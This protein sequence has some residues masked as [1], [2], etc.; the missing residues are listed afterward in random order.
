MPLARSVFGR[1]I[2]VTDMDFL[3][4]VR[5][6]SFLSEIVYIVLNV[7]LA[8][9]L[10]FLVRITGSPFP[11]FAFVI[12]SMWRV[13]AVRPR[14]WVAHIQA[15]LVC[16]IV[17]IS[18]VV[19]L[20]VINLANIGDLNS[21]IVQSIVA[22]FFIA[23]SLFLKPQSKRFYVVLQAGVA[24]FVGIAAIYTVSYG[25]L[26]LLVVL[27]V[28][29]VGYATARH[30]LSNYEE[31]HLILLSLAWGLVMAEIGWLAYHWTIAYPI[32]PN[33]LLPQI[34]I[35]TLSYG[36]LT[37]KMYDAY[38]HNQA[39]RFNDVFLPLS[40]AINISI[41]LMLFFNKPGSAS[42]N[43]LSLIATLGIMLVVESI[44]YLIINQKFFAQK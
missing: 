2:L 6:R 19:F 3:K 14:F 5:R 42:I 34:S 15:N 38:F 40:F 10:V 7:G 13:L 23:W 29:I 26:V 8:A 35:I 44:I 27:M 20:Y 37:Y 43:V 24:L 25:W 9:V 41:V 39:I 18:F 31:P 28:W 36:F 30:V 16:F 4:T 1:G 32:L 21:L 22:V 12:L 17:S 11:A 33:I